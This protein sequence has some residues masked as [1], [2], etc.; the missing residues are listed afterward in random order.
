MLTPEN[1]LPDFSG[2]AFAFAFADVSNDDGMWCRGGRRPPVVHRS[3][4]GSGRTACAP[5]TGEPIGDSL[6]VA[7]ASV[8]ES[9]DCMLFGGR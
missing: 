4:A 8:A 9:V 2:R 3:A 5:T 7:S 6:Y 1:A